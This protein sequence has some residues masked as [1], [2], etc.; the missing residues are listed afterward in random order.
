M[1]C[2]QIPSFLTE[3]LNNVAYV[4]NLSSIVSI[5][6]DIQTEF[7]LIRKS[8]MIILKVLGINSFWIFL[9]MRNQRRILNL[10]NLSMLVMVKMNLGIVSWDLVEKK[11]DRCHN[12]VFFENKTIEDLKKAKKVDS[13]ISKA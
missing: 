7:G 4:I 1:L 3:A 12:V 13:Q 2:C 9:R 5:Y 11:L 10:G 6:G 8:L